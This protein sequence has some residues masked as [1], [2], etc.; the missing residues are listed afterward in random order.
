MKLKNISL[1]DRRIFDKYLN[2]S[3]HELSAYAFA[4]I[5]IWKNLFDIRWAIIDKALCVFFRDKIGCFLY[6][7]PLSERRRP[8]AIREAF[9]ILDRFNANSEISRIENAQIADLDYYRSLGYLCRQK[10]PEYLCDRDDLIEL[11]G[12]AF[13]SK[14]SCFNY[15]LR[16]YRFQYR[17]YSSADKISCLRLHEL[18]SKERAAGT[19]DDLYRMMLGDSYQALKVS[20]SN[21]NHLKLIARVVTVSGEL[22]AFTLGYRLSPRFFCILFEIADLSIKGLAQF[23]FRQFSLEAQATAVYINIMD[24]SGLEN[25]RRVKLSYRP[26]RLIHPYIVKRGEF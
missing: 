24:D 16:N 4:N 26:A 2:L 5:Y 21:Y 10:D 14:R 3:E 19:N 1:K 23:I 20:L 25:L 18:W 15:F 13:K 17:P 12:N 8:G 9:E 22:K 6:L 7:P 11:K